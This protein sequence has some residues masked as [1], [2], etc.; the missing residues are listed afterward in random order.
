MRS[1]RASCRQPFRSLG[2]RRHCAHTKLLLR[3]QNEGIHAKILQH[4]DAGVAHVNSQLLRAIQWQRAGNCTRSKGSRCSQGNGNLDERRHRRHTDGVQ[5][6]QW[7]VP[8]RQPGARQL[9]R[10]DYRARILDGLGI[11]Q[12]GHRSDARCSA[13]PDRGESCV[14]GHGVHRGS[15]DRHLGQPLRADAGHPGSYR[16]AAAGAECDQCHHHRSRR[17]RHGRPK[18]ARIEHIHQLRTGKLGQRQRQRAGRHRQSVHRGWHGCDQHHSP[19]RAEP[20]AEFGCLAG[21]QRS[22]QHVLRRLRSR[23]R[24]SDRHD[25]QVRYQSVPWPGQRILPISK[26]GGARRIRGAAADPGE[27][28]SRQQHVLCRGR[29]GNSPQ[30]VLFLCRL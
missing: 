18:L 8:F 20:D 2:I 11:V 25:H 26:P 10:I 14:H 3:G 19:R 13:D 9:H 6:R 27:P 12:S 22:D 1:F 21:G 30:G 5:Q 17:Y 15:A 16:P 29:P 24:H 28:I 7:R 23:G 4:P